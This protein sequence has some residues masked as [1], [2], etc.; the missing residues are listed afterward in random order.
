MPSARETDP[1]ALIT[2][3]ELPPRP[4][5]CQH[6]RVVDVY[7]DRLPTGG[8]K[9]RHCGAAIAS[10]DVVAYATIGVRM[11]ALFLDALVVGFPTMALLLFVGWIETDLAPKDIRGR[12]TQPA[13]FWIT[14]SFI[15]IVVTISLAYLLIGNARGRTIGKRATGLAVVDAVTGYAPGTASSLT[16]TEAQALTVLTLGVGYVVAVRDPRRQTLHDRIA[17]TIVIDI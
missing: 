1:I 8:E 13:A 3:P 11:I 16:R 14:V 2:G 5:R 9:C 7:A 4:Y 6:C 17:N 12:V 15:A 10:A